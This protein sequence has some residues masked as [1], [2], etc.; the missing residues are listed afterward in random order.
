MYFVDRNVNQK[1]KIPPVQLSGS[2]TVVLNGA[3]TTI[4]NHC[5]FFSS[6]K[7]LLTKE[8]GLTGAALQLRYLCDAECA[9]GDETLRN[10]FKT[11]VGLKF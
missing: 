5:V 6:D 4:L 2:G 7:Q 3:K 1:V 9:S 10:T 11:N 8:E